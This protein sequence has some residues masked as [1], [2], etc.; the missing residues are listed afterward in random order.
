MWQPMLPGMSRAI[1]LP[2]SPRLRDIYYELPPEERT[3]YLDALNDRGLPAEKLVQALSR[4]EIKVSASLIRTHRRTN[5][6]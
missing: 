4:F 1:H 2:E 6:I 5:G 3:A